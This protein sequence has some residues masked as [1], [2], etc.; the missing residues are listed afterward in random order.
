VNL[1]PRGR[2]AAAD[3]GG[4]AQFTRDDRGVAGA[5]AAIADDGR[6]QACAVVA[7]PPGTRMPAPDNWLII[8][9]GEAFFAPARS[10][11]DMR[12]CPRGAV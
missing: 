1:Q 5:P 8:S 7:K 2:L 11:S 10:T 12:S 3:Q 9:P 4:N 6:E